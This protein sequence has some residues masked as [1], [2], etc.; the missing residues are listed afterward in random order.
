MGLSKYGYYPCSPGAAL[1]RIFGFDVGIKKLSLVHDKNLLRN[2]FKV[3][4]KYCGHYKEPNEK[5]DKNLISK[6]WQL[7]YKNY[8]NNRP[9]LSVY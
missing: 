3:L 2:Q 9:N 8:K 6:S 7:A 5:V 1:D 4:C